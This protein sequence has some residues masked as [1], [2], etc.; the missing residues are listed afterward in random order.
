MILAEPAGQPDRGNAGGADAVYP[1]RGQVTLNVMCTN[2]GT[3]KMSRNHHHKQ[4]KMALFPFRI[5]IYVGIV[6]LLSNINA[7]VDMFQHPNIPY[8]DE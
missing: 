6:L 5:I 3:Y 2:S 4:I 8:F 1:W 7:V